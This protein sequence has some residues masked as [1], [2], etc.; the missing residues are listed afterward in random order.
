MKFGLVLT[1]SGKADKLVDVINEIN[2]SIENYFKNN[3]YGNSLK[4]LVV[5]LLW[6]DPEFEK[7]HEIEKK[8]FKSKKLL[9]FDVMLDYYTIQKATDKEMEKHIISK[10]IDSLNIINELEIVNF[11]LKKFKNDI[12]ILFS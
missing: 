1:V 6:I 5:G 12:G 2:M 8:Y 4:S 10:I 9:E 3:N 11:D 7:Y